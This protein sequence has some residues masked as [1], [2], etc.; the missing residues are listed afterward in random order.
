WG[1]WHTPL[2][3]MIWDTHYYTPYIG[4]VLMTMSISFVYSYIYEKSN[5][6]L[7]IIILFHGSCNAAHALLY[8]F[9]D[10]LPASEQYLYWIYVALNIVAAIVVIIL[11]RRNPSREQ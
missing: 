10:D 3:F 4:F 1:L 6:N 5:G 8:L 2:W 7:L 11:R 9:Y